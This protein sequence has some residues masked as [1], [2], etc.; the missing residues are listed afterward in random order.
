MKASVAYK[1][2]DNI[3]VVMLAFKNFKTALSDE[4][5]QVN[6]P[7]KGTNESMESGQVGSVAAADE[8]S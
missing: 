7:L 8:Q 1:T 3:T 6:D 2:L 5:H 4:Y